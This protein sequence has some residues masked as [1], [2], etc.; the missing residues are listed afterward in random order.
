MLFSKKKPFPL[1]S[2]AESDD[3]ERFCPFQRV[4]QEIPSPEAGESPAKLIF[5]ET[6][7]QGLQ[8][9]RTACKI[10]VVRICLVLFAGGT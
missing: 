10:N 3:K 4:H 5:V 1:L 2:P 6:S 7:D 8:S 9:A